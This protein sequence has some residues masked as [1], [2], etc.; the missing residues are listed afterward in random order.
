MQSIKNQLKKMIVITVAVLIAVTVVL[1]KNT[2]YAKGGQILITAGDKVYTLSGEELAF[3]NG[4]YHVKCLDGVVE[5]IYYDTLISPKNAVVKFN[6][7]ANEKFSFEKEIDGKAVDIKKLKEDINSALSNG[8]YKVRASFVILKPEVTL[9]SLK[10][11]TFERGSFSTDYTYS[12]PNRKHNVEL[13]VNKI[14]G[15]IVE[16]GEIFSF[17]QTVGKRVEENGF[18]KAVVIE[19]GEYTEGVGGGVCQVSSTLYNC[20]LISGLEVIERYQHSILPSYVEPSFDAMVSGEAFDLKIKNSTNGKIYI[21]AKANGNKIT[22]TVYGER[23]LF[24][25]ERLSKTI[26][27]IVPDK[28]EVVNDDSL[29]VGETLVVKNSKKGLKSEGYLI[30]YSGN[31]RVKNIKLSSNRYK[32]VRGKIL[33]GSKVIDN[34]GQIR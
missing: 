8:V 25:Y 3:Y 16:S 5:G 22:F 6:P 18:K 13:A 26:E 23:S 2:A 30:V 1:C 10:N 4:R 29:L 20:A 21:L 17:N 24:R 11:S 14:N 34:N 19:N 31:E 27:E 15:S 33:V 12:M 9:K 7:N 32:A 28:D